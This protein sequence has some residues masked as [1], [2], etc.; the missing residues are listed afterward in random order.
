M[1]SSI[2]THRQTPKASPPVLESLLEISLGMHL[3]FE[4][5]LSYAHVLGFAVNMKSESVIFS[6]IKIV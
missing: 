4:N 5:F 6:A 1:K 3:R 2:C